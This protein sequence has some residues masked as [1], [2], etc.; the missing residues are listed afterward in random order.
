MTIITDEKK[1]DEILHRSVKE[2]LPTKEKLKELLMSGKKIRIYIGADATGTALHLGHAT[3]YMIL[4]KFRQLGH[5][6]IILIGDFTSRIGDPTDK[7]AARVQLTRDQVLE[8]CKTWLTQLKPIID[9]DN[10]DNPVKVVYNNDWLSKM[11]FEDVID[12]SSNFTVQQM[13]ERDMFEKRLNENKPIYVHEFFYPLMQGW[14]SVHLDIDIEMCGN[15]QKFNA[16]TG[17]TLV[18][19]Y[20]NKEKFV[21]IT[22][23]LENPVTKEKMM[24]KSL[25]TGVF[26]DASVNDMF[27]G[28][29]AQ[30]DE[31]IPQLF[32]DCTNYSLEEIEKIKSQL[33]SGTN[34]RDIK[35]LLAKEIVKMYHSQED[36]DKAEQYF[37]NT[38]TKKEIPDDV[39]EITPSSYDL[40]TILLESK[41]VESKG[42]AR[43]VIDQGGV[44]VNGEVVK[45]LDI[46]IDK[47]S[48]IQKGK[49][50]FIKVK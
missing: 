27:G 30:A 39:S 9:I 50:G 41:L 46:T 12:L 32:T 24:S 47:D 13:L 28:M 40:M 6:V 44:K 38:F 20:K 33:T 11:T 48:V 15:D 18:Q 16:L 23:L 2:I 14:D 26:L 17:R 37:I 31:N 3:N 4:E 22:T 7:T 19:R 36:A 45:E 25:G 5:E 10:K 29:M 34:P 8:N 35:I 42:E 43:R 1:I 49:M 21:F